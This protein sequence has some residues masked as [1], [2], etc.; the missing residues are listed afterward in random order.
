MPA[1][2]R[3]LVTILAAF[4]TSAGMVGS[5]PSQGGAT[6]PTSVKT[7]TWSGT[8]SAA[9]TSPDWSDGA[10]WQGGVAPP[11]ATAVNLFFPA[12]TCSAGRQCGQ[13]SVN[14]IAGVVVERLT[15]V[16][17]AV[18]GTGPVPPNYVLSG[19]AITL[20]GGIHATG[21]KS[22]RFP[23]A[24][25]LTMPVVIGGAQTWLVDATALYLNDPVTGGASARLLVYLG[26]GADVLMTGGAHLGALTMVGT[27][28]AHAGV[29]AGRN[30]QIYVP[31]DVPFIVTGSVS[32]TDA[33]AYFVGHFGSLTTA[34]AE[35]PIGG[36]SPPSEGILSS[37][38]PIAFDP[39]SNLQLTGLFMDG[40]S[41]PQPGVDYPQIRAGGPVALRG[42]PAVISAGCAQE[43]GIVYTLIDA[44]GGVS[45]SMSQDVDGTIT[46]IPQGGLIETVPNDADG[47]CEGPPPQWVQIR[48]DDQAGTVTATTVAGP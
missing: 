17:G 29:H 28:A 21:Q 24:P 26:G 31:T 8:D 44:K 35:L 11:A 41:D 6:G 16:T 36:S 48:Y 37:D 40:S 39:A 23:T 4:A 10:N 3:Q 25:S 43:L 12:L 34:G 45:G 33:S 5:F 14:D 2:I 19:D 20:D 7:F 32:V 15:I 46:P 47:S 42:I 13:K 30:G 1:T 9:G 18:T 22:A 27:N 38:G